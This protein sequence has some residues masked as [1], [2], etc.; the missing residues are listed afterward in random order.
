M[1]NLWS[2]LGVVS[3]AFSHQELKSGMHWSFLFT[4]FSSV[5]HDYACQHG[6]GIGRREATWQIVSWCCLIRLAAFTLCD[7]S[8]GAFKSWIFFSIHLL[9]HKF[10]SRAGSLTDF[11]QFPVLLAPTGAPSRH[12]FQY[13]F[14]DGHTGDACPLNSVHVFSQ[15]QDLKCYVWFSS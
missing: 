10:W 5:K 11:F 1:P 8:I 9:C 2:I 13:S 12:I 14:T 4:L 6:L 15:L 3:P 7:D